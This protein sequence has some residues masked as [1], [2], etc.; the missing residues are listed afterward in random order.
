MSDSFNA[1]RINLSYSSLK[2]KRRKTHTLGTADPH[3][4]LENQL[5]LFHPGGE[6]YV[7]HIYT[8]PLTHTDFQT[9]VLKYIPAQFT[10]TR[11]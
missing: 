4:I 10:L 8:P 5:T 2:S 6:D 7:H 9:F 3:Q 1:F 11:S